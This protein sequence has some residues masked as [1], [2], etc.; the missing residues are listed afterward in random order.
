VDLNKE[1]FQ[2]LWNEFF[3]SDD[4]DAAGNFLF[5]KIDF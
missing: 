3:T 5:G 4:V 1:R 2:Q